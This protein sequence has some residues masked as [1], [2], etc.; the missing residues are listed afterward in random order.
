MPILPDEPGLRP[1]ETR[2]QN[3][4]GKQAQSRKAHEAF[5]LSEDV[6]WGRQ[7]AARAD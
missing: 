7:A 2:Q 3:E 6:D 1:G 4:A 5:I